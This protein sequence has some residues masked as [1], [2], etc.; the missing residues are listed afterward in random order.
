[1]DSIA[2]HGDRRILQA[3]VFCGGSPD[4]RDHVPPRVLLD[5]PYPSELHVV[6][7]CLT[8][9]NGASADETYLACLVECVV[10]GSTDP[11]RVSRPAVRAALLHS[12]ALAGRIEACRR[13]AGGSTIFEPEHDRVRSCLTKL[14]RAHA[15]YELHEEFHDAPIGYRAFPLVSLSADE[16]LDFEASA[17]GPMWP[18]VGS[19]AMQR[20]V[21]GYPGDRPGWIVVQEGRYRYA[22]AIGNG[23]IVRIVLSEYLG[24][25]VIWDF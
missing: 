14:A 22:A 13:S 25:E 23:R 18:E 15:G 3:C 10:S 9:N 16:R 4:T 17:G 11:N 24:C 5:K 21:E 6:G 7:A 8:C 1:M 2:S 12:P 19:R 20:L